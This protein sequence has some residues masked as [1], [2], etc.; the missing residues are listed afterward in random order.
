MTHASEHTT[1][2][3]WRRLPEERPQQILQAAIE[4][5]GEHGIAGAKLEEIATRAGLSK[6]TIYLYFQNKEELFREVVRQI[7]VPRMREVE[8]AL[9]AGTAT[10]QIESYMRLQWQHFDRPG[11]AGWIKLVLIEL[12]KHPDLAEFYF[13]EA[14]AVSNQVLGDI[15]RRGMDAGEFRRAEPEAMVSVIK[16]IALMHVLWSQMPA[17][18]S[19]ARN[20]RRGATIDQIVDFVLHALRPET[21]TMPA[22]TP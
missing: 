15:L 4:V 3:K 11:T 19:P 8:R 16:A 21:A 10:E 18:V 22:P 5:F 20:N 1:D 7:L 2:P 14:I 9:D 17:P 6:G 13:T 12:P